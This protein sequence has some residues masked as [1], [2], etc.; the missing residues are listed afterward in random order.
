MKVTLDTHMLFD[1]QALE[2]TADSFNRDSIERAVPGLHGV[3]SID[4]G[5]RGDDAGHASGMGQYL[6]AAVFYALIYQ[7][8]PEG[9]GFLIRPEDTAKFMQSIAA[10]TVLLNP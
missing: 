4:L 9:L 8:S 10:E 6:T 3:L 5:S 2:I 7:E 1:E